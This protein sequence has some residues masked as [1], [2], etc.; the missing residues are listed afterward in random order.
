MDVSSGDKVEDEDAVTAAEED[1]DDEEE[2]EEDKVLI[3]TD[4]TPGVS[5]HEGTRKSAFSISVFSIKVT[6]SDDAAALTKYSSA[7]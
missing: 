6:R 1:D 4:H 5:S 3:S 2:E 7:M